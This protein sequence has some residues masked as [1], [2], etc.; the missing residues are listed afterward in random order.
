MDKRKIIKSILI[1][2]QLSPMEPK[3][4]ALWTVLLQTFG[5]SELKR[6]DKILE[7][8][9]DKLMDLYLKAQKINA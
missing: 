8:E 3:E 2:L 6:L 9:V 4:K 7:K 1:R 5:D